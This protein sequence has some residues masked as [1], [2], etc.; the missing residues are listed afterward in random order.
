MAKPIHVRIPPELR[1]DFEEVLN[2]TGLGETQFVKAAIAALV[3]YVREHGEITIPIALIPKSKQQKAAK[4]AA[5]PAH[6]K[7]PGRSDAPIALPVNPSTDSTRL[8]L[9][10]DAHAES[11]PPSAPRSALP[12]KPRTAGSRATARK[13]ATQ[14]PGKK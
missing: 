3:E 13:I 9:N 5:L 7:K 1:A 11:S 8:S 4:T 6:E 2:V 14:P 10:E 12:F